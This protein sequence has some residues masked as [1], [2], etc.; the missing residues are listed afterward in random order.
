M[1]SNKTGRVVD[2]GLLLLGDWLA[3]VWMVVWDWGLLLHNLCFC[4]CCS[5]FV[6][7]FVSFSF[8]FF[9]S[10]GCFFGG[11]GDGGLVQFGP[12]SLLL[13]KLSLTQPMTFFH[14]SSISL[15]HLTVGLC[16]V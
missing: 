4:C 2:Q 7:L 16:G 13:I 12:S 3:I 10:V 6:C 1:F 8:S 9:F 14:F 5:V 15:L 11:G